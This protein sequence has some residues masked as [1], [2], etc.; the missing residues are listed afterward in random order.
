MSV[1]VYDLAHSRAG[2]KGNTSNISV[3]AYNQA[4]WEI[5]NL[6]CIVFAERPKLSPY[7]DLIRRRI[8]EILGIAETA[9]G[10]QAKTGEAVDAVGRQEAIMTQCVVLLAAR[11]YGPLPSD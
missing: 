10:L 8:A 11:K 5:V 7:K 4:G 1:R 3:V 9:I 2:D 6:D